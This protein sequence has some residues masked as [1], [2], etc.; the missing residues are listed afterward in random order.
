MSKRRPTRDRRALSIGERSF[1]TSTFVGLPPIIANEE[2]VIA[3]VA[4]IMNNQR[5]GATTSPPNAT[6]N[7]NTS[8]SPEGTRTTPAIETVRQEE[9]IATVP[10]C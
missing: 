10:S 2:K 4:S 5:S 9:I 3:K 1:L 6:A 7:K 8:S